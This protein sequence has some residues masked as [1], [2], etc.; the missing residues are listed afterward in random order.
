MPRLFPKQPRA[1]PPQASFIKLRAHEH[2][3]KAQNAPSARARIAPSRGQGEKKPTT[4]KA[5]VGLV[6]LK[7]LNPLIFFSS[8]HSFSSLYTSH[9][10][11]PAHIKRRERRLEQENSGPYIF[12]ARAEAVP[13]WRRR[14]KS[15]SS[16]QRRRRSSPMFVLLK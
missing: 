9:P 16:N 15:S 1:S 12:V 5:A 11:T 14:R 13:K 6:I 3:H 4:T 7:F 2:M 8:F 10:F